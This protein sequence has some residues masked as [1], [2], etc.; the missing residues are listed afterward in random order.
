M[1]I[2]TYRLFIWICR[3]VFDVIYCFVTEDDNTSGV[4][5]SS[6]AGDYDGYYV[7]S[8]EQQHHQQQQQTSHQPQSGGHLSVGGQ[9]LP[10]DP[11]DPT[12]G[13]RMTVTPELLGLMPGNPQYTSGE[14]LSYYF[15]Y[16]PSYDIAPLEE[17]QTLFYWI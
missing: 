4:S 5:Q 1:I 8:E 6:S 12:G 7:K 10:T 2:S 11:N 17:L 13:Q 3:R 16:S 15:T 9:H 14:Y